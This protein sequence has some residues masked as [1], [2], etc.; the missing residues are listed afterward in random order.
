MRSRSYFSFSVL[1]RGA[2]GRRSLF[3]P[4]PRRSRVRGKEAAAK[5]YAIFS[6]SRETPR[7]VTTSM[8]GVLRL[9]HELTGPRMRE[10][11][12]QLFSEVVRVE[13]NSLVRALDRGH[14]RFRHLGRGKARG[15]V[16]PHYLPEEDRNDAQAIKAAVE[17]V[18][19]DIAFD[20]QQGT[21]IGSGSPL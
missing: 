11:C 6:I 10:A 5:R 1:C 15:R 20:L 19:S 21:P 7:S 3:V 12:W 9:P 2:T 17:G 16:H 14:I 8:S 13:D 18:I 4:P